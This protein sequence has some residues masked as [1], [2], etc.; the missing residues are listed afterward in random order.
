[1]CLI[2]LDYQV[3]SGAPLVLGANREEVYSR[4]S[5]AP[6]WRSDPVV[7]AG[8]DLL[9]GGTWL[10][11]SETGLVVAATN[12]REVFQAAGEPRSRGQLCFDALRQP[13]ATAALDW[14]WQHLQD[15][16][17]RPCNLLIADAATAGVIHSVPAQTERRDLAPG[18]Y[19]LTDGDIDNL[20]G[21]RE[22]RATRLSETSPAGELDA[23]LEQ[24]QRIL[25][26]ADP[27]APEHER[28]CRRGERSG[29]V[30]SAVLAIMAPDVVAARYH[31]TGGPP[32]TH[33]FEDLSIELQQGG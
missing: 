14:A 16:A 6:G 17:Y 22:S 29:T 11:V 33:P 4:S 19:V 5:Q 20:T 32:Q 24:M 18:R 10:G 31:Y 30:S 3:D 8:L 13:T 26:D 25:A 9:A 1:M 15:V 28:I 23:R 7:F 2:L 21:I 12:R 27:T